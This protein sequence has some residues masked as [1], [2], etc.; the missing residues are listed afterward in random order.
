MQGVTINIDGRALSHDLLPIGIGI[1]GPNTFLSRATVNQLTVMPA[2][3]YGF[4][5]GSGIVADLQYSVG[6]D[7]S[8][9]L[10]PKFAA[11]ASASGN[12]L[13]IRG[14]TINIDGRA[15]S[16]DLLPFGIQPPGTWLPRATVNQLTLIPATGYSFQPGGLLADFSYGVGR[17]GSIQ[18]DPNLASCASAS[19]NT[20]T[21]RG[22]T[23][24][25]DGRALSHDLLPF[26]IQPPGTWL[27]RATVNQLTL[28]PAT[29]YSFQP[30]G[31]LADFSYGVGRDG[32]IQLDPNLA[33]CASASG[34]T[35]TI[36][37]HTINIDGRA[38]SHDLLPFGIQP[39]GT[40]L[41]RATVN[42]LTLI[43]ATGY[44]FQ[45]G[46][47]LA[48]FS[49]GVGRDGSIQLDPNLASC[50]SASGNTLTIRGHTINIDGRALSHDLLPFGI[51]PPGTWLP[52]ATVNQLTLIPATGYSF[53][54]GGL[55]ADF[56]Y[57]VGRDGSIQLDPNLASCASASGNTL[58]IRGHTINIDGRALSHDLLPFG[59][60]PPGTWL[61]RA[62]VN[63]LTL[64]P[65]TGYSFQPGGLLADFSYGVGR[66]GSIQL[67]PNLASCASASG[68]TLT[69]RGHTINIDGRALSHD[70]LPFGIQPPGTW[71]PRAT[72]NQ[73]TLIPA[74]GYSFQ[75]G[76]L[77]ADFSYGVGR[78]GRLVVDPRYAGFAQ[79]N[80]QLLL[81]SG[82]LITIDGRALSHN[83]LPLLAGWTDGELSNTSIHQLAL[84]P[85]IDY[86][87]LVADGTGRV[88]LLTLDI[89]G[90]VSIT[91]DIGVRVW[92]A[93]DAV[94]P[95]RTVRVAQISGSNTDGD[96]KIHDPQGWQLLN[97]TSKW[98]AKGFDEGANAEHNGKLYFFSGDVVLSD[99]NEDPL[100][101]SHLVAWTEDLKVTW[102]ADPTNLARGFGLQ[103]VL[104]NGAYWPF[105]AEDPVGVTLSLEPAVSAFSYAGRVYVFV[106][107][108]APHY[109]GQTRPG[110]PAYGL[111]LVSTDQPDQAHVYRTEFL[112]DPRIGI[113]PADGGSHTVLGYDFVLPHDV[114]TDPQGGFGWFR[115]GKCACLFA[116]F[117]ESR[118]AGVC[119]AGG[120][121]EA[122]A[123]NPGISGFRY[124]IPHDRPED[125]LNQGKWRRCGKCQTMFFIGS[126][127]N[128]GICPADRL[129]HE[130]ADQTDFVLPHDQP[131]DPNHVANWRR[132]R[133]CSC[134][135]WDGLWMK[136]YCVATTDPKNPVDHIAISQ[137]EDLFK[138]L[139][140]ELILTYDVQEDSSHQGNWRYCTKCN[141][142]FNASDNNKC[143]VD[144]KQHDNSN[145]L[146]PLPGR[147]EPPVGKDFVLLHDLA[148]NASHQAGFRRCTKCGLLYSEFSFENWTALT[149]AG[150]TGL[151][152][153]EAATLGTDGQQHVFYRGTDGAIKHI[154]WNAAD[155]RFHFE[156][157]TALA[158]AGPTGLA[159]G[160][161]A[162][163]VTAGQQ[164]VFYRGTDG[165]INHIFWNAADNRFHFQDWTVLAGAGPAG[166][167]AG[168]P[169]TVV[170]A[171]QQ[172]VFYR[173]ADDAIKHIFWN[174]AD[175]RFHFQDWTVLAG[176]GPAG[177]AAG[178]PATLGTD[179]QQHVFYRGTDGAIKHIFWNAADGSFHF[180]DWTALAGA[181]PAGLAAGDPA[182]MV[183]ASQQ[184]VFYRGT[185]G[186]IKHI[187]W[188]AADRSFHFEDWTALA[189][190]GPT[191]LAAGDPATMV[192]AS[193]QHVFYRDTDGA[194]KHIFWNAADRSFHFEDWT[195][196][197][198]ADPADSAA[199]DPAAL[200][201]DGQQHV[202]YRG[203][204]GA[205]K[206][207]FW[208]VENKCPAGDSHL[209]SVERFVL[210]RRIREDHHNDRDWRFCTKCFGLVSTK[211]GRPFFTLDSAVV[212]NADIS[213]LPSQTGDGLIILGYGWTDFHLAWMP[214]GLS[215]PRLQDVQYYSGQPGA[216]SWN[217]IVGQ[218]TAL[219]SIS[220]PDANRISLAWL[221]GP[222]RWILLYSWSDAVIARFGTTPWNWSDEIKIISRDSPQSGY[223]YSKPWSDEL[224]A[225]DLSVWAFY[226]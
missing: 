96:P 166:L 104:Q 52:R 78:D 156:D 37:G 121:H 138:A 179:G 150:P 103:A 23:I 26:G 118:T 7:G 113:C 142:L 155:N 25:I 125:P 5:P 61:P 211:D 20:L 134:L 128:Q 117:N 31:L 122:V 15:L 194:I 39:P 213:S 169:A 180:E 72:V 93:R 102:T 44:S 24:N 99:F 27:P 73:L 159:A 225:W 105:K 9:Q 42:Q 198:Y 59:I 168:D 46:G 90:T 221:E 144:G 186:A 53:Q 67:D 58:T 199:G 45:P 87:I 91:P 136:R 64:I 63:Q 147:I 70:L 216:P 223:L 219:F 38:L 149:G 94:Q 28:I 201:T 84:L 189:G 167:A 40:W 11:F 75:P 132:C 80:S 162:T 55:L 215:G 111:Y 163:M 185:D 220:S 51:Q 212:H 130:A 69:I 83:L 143:P 203:T 81:L 21:I 68:N 49:Y 131:E 126:S 145:G 127:P 151:A 50:A 176:A 141:G 124:A 60:Q 208:N 98:G 107:L 29:G 133:L 65:A 33:S 116:S 114:P 202:F 200:G 88:L 224:K 207:I 193:Q 158:G 4:R 165:A 178:E 1:A 209:P 218:C 43:P 10:D 146:K 174:A 2:S 79:V 135:Y 17:D 92:R 226:P 6:Q 22:H 188:N 184:H 137:S 182:T 34:N 13:T 101:N 148:E 86:A 82:Y 152:A 12:T 16:H 110:D 108:G 54:P 175:D 85:A 154:F 160:D 172:H 112:F 217:K 205:I 74:T 123:P 18:L 206:H 140:D 115:C 3:G 41:P 56:S 214:L 66:D 195:A 97:D 100:N 48:D 35:L 95:L 161:P 171:G 139:Q 191:G 177:L 164:H 222:Q 157:W 106:G 62:T 19:G 190:A 57:G 173:G 204:D 181:G 192:T 30:G 89:F 170:T 109:S 8:I 36:R 187:F 14:H 47:L 76:G 119:Q 77:L 71:L 197:A 32:S 210:P 183:T 120:T 153:G 196:S 129:R